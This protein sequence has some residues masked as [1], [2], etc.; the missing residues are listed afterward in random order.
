MC[1]QFQRVNEVNL[2][3]VANVFLAL[4]KKSLIIKMDLF[5]SFVLFPFFGFFLTQYVLCKT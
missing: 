1:M 4:K 3:S 5:F 2:K